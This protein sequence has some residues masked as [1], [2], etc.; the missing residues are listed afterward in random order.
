M[1]QRTS[2]YASRIRPYASL[3]GV[4][5]SPALGEVAFKYTVPTGFYFCSANDTWTAVIGAGGAIGGSGTSGAIPRW[6]AG[7]TL[8][9]SL[10]F[11]GTNLIEQKNST[12]P[13]TFRVYETTASTG[14]VAQIQALSSA[15]A[16]R[17][18]SKQL[19]SG[20]SGRPY[21]FGYEQSDGTF[22]GWSVN[23]SGH[24]NVAGNTI[25]AEIGNSGSPR[26]I[27][28]GSTNGTG[29]VKIKGSTAGTITITVPDSVINQTLTLPSAAVSDAFLKNNGSGTLSWAT[30][31]APTFVVGTSGT[32]FA[33]STIGTEH[34]FNIPDASATARGFVTT[35]AQTFA[36]A[37]TFSTPVAVAS[38]GTGLASATAYA[39]LA[40][41]TTSTGAFQSLAEVGTS[42]Q[43][44]TS[45]GAGALPTFQDA[46]GGISG[47]TT[48]TIPKA[49]SATTLTDSLLKE[50]T[51]L[52]EQKSSTTAQTFRV[53]KNAQATY[54]TNGRRALVL[55]DLSNSGDPG[56]SRFGSV[57]SS[58]GAGDTNY[59]FGLYDAGTQR[60][61]EVTTGGA[62]L[63]VGG[64]FDLGSSSV[65][66]GNL[67]LSNGGTLSMYD[68]TVAKVTGGVGDGSSA[69]APDTSGLKIGADSDGTLHYGLS[70]RTANYFGGNQA[71]GSFFVAAP[72]SMG[73]G[74]PGYLRWRAGAQGT[75]SGTTPHTQV[76]REIINGTLGL[77]DNTAATLAVF[78]LASNS[79]SG[80]LIDYLVEA[81]DGTDI[82][83]ESGQVIFS[84]VNKAGSYITGITAHDTQNTVSSGT[85][86]TTWDITTGASLVNVR[87]NADTSLSPTV[88]RITYKLQNLGQQA[89]AIQ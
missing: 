1:A 51:N 85:L 59:T 30:P 35:G 73:L 10:L 21:E 31:T 58:Y 37:K 52:I 78:T 47:L 83:T 43:V 61:W 20:A 15:N 79:G 18:G 3:V 84:F 22:L 64:N 57:I 86:T 24:L 48:G 71:A 29:G 72:I 88:L 80:G 13:Q 11:Q 65:P 9:D 19:A 53:Y 8:G 77:T 14:S 5:C 33:I 68:R 75:A 67:Y 42:G 6:T 60:M 63:P 27:T 69:T 66:V 4:P 40:G 34:T 70:S 38:G 28:L 16:V 2:P 50:G 55:G 44:L 81:S 87:V 26:Y 7:S 12:N 49:A 74:K 17:M 36:G 62:L 89:V 23:T 39:L 76:D 46:A 25:N 82:Q 56:N 41:G 54:T 32:D 45:N